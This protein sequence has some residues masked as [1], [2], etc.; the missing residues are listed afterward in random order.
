MIKIGVE[1]LEPDQEALDLMKEYQK[2]QIISDKYS[3]DLLHIA[4]ATISAEVLVSWNFKHIVKLD[5]IQ[6]FNATNLSCGYRA[7][8][9]YSPREVAYYEEE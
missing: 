6:Q 4:I 9:I 3:N 2:K 1:I 8:T 7:I 5:K